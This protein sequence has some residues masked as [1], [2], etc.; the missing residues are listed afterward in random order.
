MVSLNLFFVY[1]FVLFIFCYIII[2]FPTWLSFCM[3]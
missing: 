1:V 2:A 3:Y